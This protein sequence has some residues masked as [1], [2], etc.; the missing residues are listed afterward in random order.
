[1]TD[2]SNRTAIALFRRDLRVDDNAALRAAMSEGVAVAL[3]VLDDRADGRPLGVA[4]RWWLQQ[5]LARLDRHLRNLGVPLIVRRGAQ[6]DAV[7]EVA[8][9]LGASAVFWNRRYTPWG[10]AADARLEAGVGKLGLATA[11]FAGSYLR[12]PGHV[13]TRQG[14]WYKVFGPF[15]RASLALGDPEP[16]LPVP[17][18]QRTPRLSVRSVEPGGMDW[19]PVAP[20]Q[21]E[22]FRQAWPDGGDPASEA[23]AAFLE[24][25]SRG[26]SETR[27]R[28][29]ID[30]T[31]A[32][33]PYLAFGEL[34]P[35][36]IWH[37]ARC[38]RG[39][40]PGG[41]K[42]IAVF[43][44]QLVWRDFCASLLYRNP[45][46]NARPVQRRFEGFP[47]RNDPR[48]LRAWQRGETGYPW[49]DAGM[50]QLQATGWMHN[51]VRMGAAS[52]LTKHLLLPWQFGE[53]WFW[54]ALVDADPAQNIANWQWVAG[55]GADAAPY[56]RIFNPVTQGTKFDLTGAYLRR[57]QPE[58]TGYRPGAA[59]IAPIVEHR[60]ARARALA[61]FRSLGA[62]R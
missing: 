18:S 17:R 46:M 16:P 10:A 59:G 49:V 23:L 54:E 8:T 27:N 7:S 60:E 53:A 51:R 36:R 19:P 2:G 4:G 1:M 22:G 57:W 20:E 32:L 14:G 44:R 55:C 52:F 40:S 33:S 24:R 26:Y 15:Y 61:A 37:A 41:T 56:F 47:W 11:S 43:L 38:I 35:R 12:E 3:Y 28:P 48:E 58:A 39:G 30:G 9:A 34:S 29:D 42:G 31:S 13:R 62:A 5:A 6:E 45:D 21:S 25:A 50:R